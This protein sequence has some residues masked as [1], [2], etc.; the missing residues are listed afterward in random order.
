MFVLVSPCDRVFVYASSTNT[1]QS[2]ALG[3]SGLLFALIVMMDLLRSRHSRQGVS[4]IDRYPGSFTPG[5]HWPSWTKS[6]P[7]GNS[8]LHVGEVLI[9]A[10]CGVPVFAW[11][12][13]T[14]TCGWGPSPCGC[15]WASAA[16]APVPSTSTDGPRPS[17]SGRAAGVPS[18]SASPRQTT[19]EEQQDGGVCASVRSGS[20]DLVRRR[21]SP[22][23]PSCL[24]FPI[25]L[26]A[27]APNSILCIGW[28]ALDAGSALASV[29]G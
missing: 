3:I 16:P 22:W 13:H 1:S 29:R 26:P 15:R 6:G 10:L 17:A 25:A 19:R 14:N 20:L 2:T 24:C 8:G 7:S 5:W 11:W 4:R 23:L 18:P 9:N 27:F 28:P 21:S 12:R